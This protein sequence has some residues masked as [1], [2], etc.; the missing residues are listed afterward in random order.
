M[1]LLHSILYGFLNIFQN[2]NELYYIS[3]FCI[4]HNQQQPALSIGID[5]QY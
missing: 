3:M 1:Y 2:K 5:I 4:I